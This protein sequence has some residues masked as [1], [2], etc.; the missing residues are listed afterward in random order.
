MNKIEIFKLTLDYYK[1]C[2]LVYYR[3]GK[4]YK[5]KVKGWS[6]VQ[7]GQIHVQVYNKVIC[8]GNATLT[9]DLS[10]VDS[11]KIKKDGK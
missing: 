10:N 7:D 3:G 9:V 11:L 1:K 6:E 8:G 4:A 2:Y 5:L